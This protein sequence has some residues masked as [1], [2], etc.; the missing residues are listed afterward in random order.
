MHTEA[1]QRLLEATVLMVSLVCQAG[2]D[3][4]A[5]TYYGLDISSEALLKAA[6]RVTALLEKQRGG[7]NPAQ[8]QI[9]WITCDAF[10]DDA[11]ERGALSLLPCL[12]QNFAV[13]FF[14]SFLFWF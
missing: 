4:R 14:P 11:I 9:H 7:S 13:F 2:Q 12:V 5:D 3:Y 10:S 1:G 8:P 6:R